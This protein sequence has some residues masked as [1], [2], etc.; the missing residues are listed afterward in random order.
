[1]KLWE[2]LAGSDK[3]ASSKEFKDALLE[4]EKRNYFEKLPKSNL[5]EIDPSYSSEYSYSPL[6]YGINPGAMYNPAY[7]GPMRTEHPDANR[8]VSL[9]LDQYPR[10]YVETE[11]Q[12][13]NATNPKSPGWAQLLKKLESIKETTKKKKFDN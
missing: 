11:S 6:D 7:V 13:L 12:L 2:L 10:E 5:K 3:K 9:L 1:M 8:G 4:L